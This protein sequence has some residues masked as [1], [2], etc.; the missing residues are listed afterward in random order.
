MH[1]HKRIIFTV[2]SLMLALTLSGAG[3]SQNRTHEQNRCESAAE[4]IALEYT[5]IEEYEV[6]AFDT[7]S[8]IAV[9]YIP[10]DE[11]MQQ[12]IDDVKRLNKRK[13]SDIYS[14]EVIKVYACEEKKAR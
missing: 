6:Q 2:L 5:G 10:S 12:W 13:T 1:K 8:A 9:K 7:L 14:G 3:K 4:T 11:Y